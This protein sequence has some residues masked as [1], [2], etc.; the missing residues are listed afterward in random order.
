VGEDEFMSSKRETE[1]SE[2]DIN[3]LNLEENNE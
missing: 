2:N 1:L 3:N